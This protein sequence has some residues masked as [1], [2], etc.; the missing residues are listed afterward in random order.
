VWSSAGFDSWPPILLFYINDPPRKLNKDNI[1]V[2]H[3]DDTSI[4]ITDTDK[5]DFEIDLNQTFRHI[6][7]WFNANIL[8]LNFQET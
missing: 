8:T 2:L 7:L 6:H 1:M 4:I 5:L 3:A